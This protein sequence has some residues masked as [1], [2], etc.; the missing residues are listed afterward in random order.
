MSNRA[1]LQGRPVTV[2][3]PKLSEFPLFAAG[4]AREPSNR[5][6]ANRIPE[7]KVAVLFFL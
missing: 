1:G 3:E 7:R 5:I 4:F 6:P 2:F